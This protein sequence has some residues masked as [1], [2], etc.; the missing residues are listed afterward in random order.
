MWRATVILTDDPLP[1]TDSLR[2]SMKSDTNLPR[3]K[4]SVQMST[5]SGEAHPCYMVS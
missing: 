2:W 4:L 1:S 3:K 5:K